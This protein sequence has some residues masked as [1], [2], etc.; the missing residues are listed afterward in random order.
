MVSG[1]DI[2]TV[3]RLMGWR[4]IGTAQKYFK[5]SNIDVA[6]AAAKHP[7]FSGKTA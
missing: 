3:M 2:V 5:A 7:F 4:S 1:L 6:S